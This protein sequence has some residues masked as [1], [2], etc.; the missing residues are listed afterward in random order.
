M[1]YLDMDTQ[2]KARYGTIR[3]MHTHTMPRC[4]LCT[5]TTKEGAMPMHYKLTLNTRTTM[6]W[7]IMS[8]MYTLCMMGMRMYTHLPT[9]G[10][11][12][13]WI[14]ILT[15]HGVFCTMVWGCAHLYVRKH[16]EVVL[17]TRDLDH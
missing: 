14:T 6:V 10:G 9:W 11:V 13:T 2:G 7:L 16:G 3:P 4:D 1:Q 8:T 17:S 15:Y 12:Y 5:H